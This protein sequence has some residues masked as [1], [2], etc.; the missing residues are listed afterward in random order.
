MKKPQ[1]SF[2]VEYKSGRRKVDSKVPSSIWGNLDLKSVA[3]DVEAV[4]PVQGEPS[5]QPERPAPATRAPAQ[6]IPTSAG[7]DVIESP[8]LAS[9]VL[10]AGSVEPNGNDQHDV[11]ADAVPAIRGRKSGAGTRR[12]RM[13]AGQPHPPERRRTPADHSG[14][15]DDLEQLEKENRLLKTM[16][17]AKLRQENSWLRERLRRR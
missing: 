5:K 15:P 1:R 6:P 7:I 10:G 14:E 3:R 12:R 2:V 8:N 11:G 4:L 9:S 13:P 17:A 16:L